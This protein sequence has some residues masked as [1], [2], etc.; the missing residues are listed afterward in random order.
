MPIVP[1][2]MLYMGPNS[3][4]HIVKMTIWVSRGI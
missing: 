4:L 2:E 1:D 3:I